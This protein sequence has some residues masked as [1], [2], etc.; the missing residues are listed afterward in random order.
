LQKISY[1][2]KIVVKLLFFLKKQQLK[3]KVYLWNNFVTQWS[4]LLQK[5][6]LT[7]IWRDSLWR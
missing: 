3:A 5:N 7:K 2:S 1:L 6:L 4:K